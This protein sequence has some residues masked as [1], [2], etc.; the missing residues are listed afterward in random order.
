MYL[1]GCYSPSTQAYH[2]IKAHFKLYR[3]LVINHLPAK[4]AVVYS[5]PFSRFNE[6]GNDTNPLAAR[7]R[8]QTAR[9]SVV[10]SGRRPG[11]E[12][13]WDHGE[14]RPRIV[15]D[16]VDRRALFLHSSGIGRN[17]VIVTFSEGGRHLFLDETRVRRRSRVFVRLVLLDQQRPLL[18]ESANLGRSH[19]DIH[20]RAKWEC[21]E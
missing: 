2:S 1:H 21:V 15:T 13:S 3:I 6:Y 17:R 10:Q 11:S 12:A 8:A 9:F 14:I 5:C 16:V 18:S 19:R 7:T 20:L 4:F